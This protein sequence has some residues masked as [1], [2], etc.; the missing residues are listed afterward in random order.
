LETGDFAD[1]LPSL[2][3]YPP[4]MDTGGWDREDDI[5]II[6]VRI[7]GARYI[8]RST[9]RLHMRVR[10]WAHAAVMRQFD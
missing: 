6:F 2:R 9:G 5:G 8:I 7:V 3:M 1:T 4:K 10:E